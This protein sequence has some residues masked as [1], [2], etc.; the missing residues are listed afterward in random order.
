VPK[1]TLGKKETLGKEVLCRVFF[2]HSV[3]KLLFAECFFT[4]GIEASLL[5]VFLHS[6][7]SFF[8]ECIF[9]TLGKELLWRVFFTLGNEN[10]KAHFE[11][12]N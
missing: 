7:K 5:S 2:L 11:A 10:F 1:K 12:V 8:T 4:L 6:T 3:Q 9:L